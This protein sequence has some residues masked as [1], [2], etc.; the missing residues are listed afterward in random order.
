M[1]NPPRRPNTSGRLHHRGPPLGVGGSKKLWQLLH[2]ALH[3]RTFM[4]LLV[5]AVWPP[6]CSL[7]PPADVR[8]LPGKPREGRVPYRVHSRPGRFVEVTQ[9]PR[10]PPRVE[11]AVLL[12]SGSRGK[13]E[14]C[15]AAVGCVTQAGP[16]GHLPVGQTVTGPV[17]SPSSPA[18]VLQ[19]GLPSPQALAPLHR[20]L[21]S[22]RQ[23][24]RQ[25]LMEQ[26][27]LN[28]TE[29]LSQNSI[30]HTFV[31]GDFNAHHEKWGSSNR[32]VASRHLA[33]SLK[34]ISHL[35]LLKTR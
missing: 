2:P 17:L 13:A 35:A 18:V 14:S 31:G 15:S 1:Q 16:S 12:P 19:P 26:R 3:K 4:L 23:P 34:G 11:Q 28:V 20:P 25:W 9:L 27:D 5:P 6:P 7:H 29:L 8:H 30:E 22:H 10:G 21:S 24:A 33:P 32:N